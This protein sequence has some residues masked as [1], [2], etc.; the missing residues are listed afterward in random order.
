MNEWI[1]VAP[2][3]ELR[4]DSLTTVRVNG[5]EMLVYRSGESYYVYPNR[6]THQDVPLSDGYLVG[7]AIVCH[8]HGAKFDLKT[9]ACLRAP[10]RGNLYGYQAIVRNEYLFIHPNDSSEKS[11]HPPEMTFRS[12]ADVKVPA[13]V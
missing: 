9:G 11:G 12:C 6:C 2:I 13:N 4:N 7:D 5:T 10:A 1:P 3:A 8:L